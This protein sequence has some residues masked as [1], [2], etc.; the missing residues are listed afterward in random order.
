MAPPPPADL[1]LGQRL[2]RLA[3]T[4]QFAWFAGHATLIICIFRYALSW[5]RMNYYSRTAQFCYRFTFIS[6]A[7]TY[8]IVVY[9]TWRARQKVNAKQPT[10][11]GYLADENIQYLLMAIV[12]LFMP[13]YPLAMLPYGIYS[14]FHVATYT[15]A[16]LIPTVIPPT[17]V[18]PRDGASPSAKPQ[19]TQHPLSDA[20]GS[21]VKKYYDSSMSIVSGLE[22]LLWIRLLLGAVFF[23]RRSW[24]LLAIY[25][26]FL[27]ARFAQSTHVQ[28]SFTQLEARVDNLIGAQ[29]TPPA[30]RQVWD[31]VKN[32]ARQ[33]HAATDVNK[34][35]NGTAAPKKA[36]LYLPQNS[37]MTSLLRQLVAGPRV[38]HEEAGLDLCYVTSKIIATS[39]P[40]QT[41]PQRAYR[42]PLDR[43]VAFLDKKHGD[44][45]AIWEFRAEGTG[46]PDEAVY[47]RIRHYPWPDHHPPPFRLV[48][49]IMA[50]MRNWLAGG[51]L[52][53]TVPDDEGAKKKGDG[54][55]V[56]V[57]CKAGKGRSGT[58][59]C[60]YLISE[61][62]WTPEDALARFTERR[63]RPKFGAG[64]SIPS[65]L[66]WVSYVDRWTK[67]GKRYVDR[68]VEIVEVHVWGLRHGVK[69]SVE[70]FEDEGKKI[71][72][73]HTFKRNE[74]IVVEGDAPGGAGVVDFVSDLAGYGLSEKEDEEIVEDADYEA[75][76]KGKKADPDG[77]ES[78]D[79][80]K[81][82]R[83]K[84]G[85]R[86]SSL[87]RKIS[88][89][90][91]KTSQT[92]S[93]MGKEKSKTIA[94]PAAT[95]APS[96]L[97]ETPAE[98]SSKSASNPSLQNAFLFADPKEPGGQAVIF[99]PETP[100]KVPNGDV[101]VSLERRNRA[102]ATV[103]LTM[104]TAVAHV[105]FNTFFEGNGPEQDGTADDS[106][107]F[108]IDWDKMDGI[109]GSSQRGTRA[110]DRLSVVWRVA[111]TSGDGTTGRTTTAAGVT[112]NEPP[113]NRP[114]PQMRPADW[115]GGD[116]DT[117][118]R[119]RLGLRTRTTDSASVSAASSVDGEEP[120]GEKDDESLAGVKVSGPLGE[121][122]LD[123][124]LPNPSSSEEKGD[125]TAK[126]GFII[127]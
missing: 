98:T 52:D 26:A 65:Q 37:T 48:P 43:L 44:G 60:S 122:V 89:R 32:G 73:L 7:L 124:T 107:V 53:G 115:K 31:G 42:N 80:D 116:E 3:Q 118:P 1:P 12:W 67:G 66:R 55:V 88:T 63:M 109:K 19:Y 54:R 117:G 49:M 27:R 72:V 50:S 45:W 70:G 126:K 21:F 2:Q 100:I 101:N 111:G 76:A 10:P 30:A 93:K 79:A 105:W 82:S 112:I 4:L 68:E 104:V 5:M 87:M 62:G 56:V 58:M 102:H 8:G 96:P 40:S 39:G 121:E 17:K 99:K 90:A 75:I 16:N 46:Y 97:L 15:R 106:G 114:V 71:K 103:G 33:F 91:P 24:I 9:K 29:G 86:A 61:C 85:S 35:I 28:N 57:H 23:Q 108:E 47:H 84:K 74:R 110:C 94:M 119:L 92:L 77:N 123:D 81:G 69:V 83:K 51:D 6:A 25:T 59:A 41:Y 64:V 125:K 78:T 36:H 18:P 34:Y 22:I 20:I 113:E 13:Q 120:V 11:L 95:E 127:E 38:K 14:V